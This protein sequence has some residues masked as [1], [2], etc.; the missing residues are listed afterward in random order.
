MCS[1]WPMRSSRR[2]GSP[3]PGGL[4]SRRSFDDVAVGVDL[5]GAEGAQPAQDWIEQLHRV[6]VGG[7]DSWWKPEAFIEVRA[8]ERAALVERQCGYIGIVVLPAVALEQLLL[9]VRGVDAV[10]GRSV[11]REVPADG[12]DRLVPSE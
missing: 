9:D 5:S 2:L 7:D 6:K 4:R 3:E 8:D 11:F 10:D 1:S 12:A